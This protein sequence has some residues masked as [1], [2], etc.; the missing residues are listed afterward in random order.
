[1][2]RPVVEFPLFYGDEREDVREFLGNYRRAGLLNGWD[3]EKLALGLPL[4]LKKHASVW[5][6]T[7]TEADENESFQVLSQKLISHF[8]SK[9]TL[10][11]LRQKLEER[12]QLLGETVADY[13][14]DILSFC[15]RLNLPKS[16]WLYCFVRGLRPEIR[17]HV[18]LQQPTDVDSALNFARLKELVTLGKSKNGQEVEECW[19]FKSNPSKE[20]IKQILRDELNIWTETSQNNEKHR[21]VNRKFRSCNFPVHCGGTVFSKK[22]KLGRYRNFKANFKRLHR[23]NNTQNVFNQ[24]KIGARL[25]WL[26]PLSCVVV[27]P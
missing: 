20:D 7:L 16:E 4:F 12:R 18:I 2:N 14:Y 17:D 13:Y 15:S 11:Q 25:N 23:R 5:F 9:V 27:N 26:A 10:W 3:E 6:K 8:E 1:M 19:K 24:G 22:P 21:R